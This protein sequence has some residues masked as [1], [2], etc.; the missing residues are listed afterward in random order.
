MASEITVALRIKPWWMALL[1]AAVTMRLT[2]CALWLAK[3]PAFEVR[4]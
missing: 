2:W 4:G 3:H 1:R